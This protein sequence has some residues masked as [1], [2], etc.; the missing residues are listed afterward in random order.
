MSMKNKLVWYLKGK[1]ITYVYIS[2][3]KT[4]LSIIYRQLKKRCDFWAP[5]P[6]IY[7]YFTY[8]T[9]FFWQCGLSPYVKR[10][11]FRI[12]TQRPSNFVNAA[13]P[14]FNQ[15]YLTCHCHISNFE[16]DFFLWERDF[17][18]PC[19]THHPI[20]KNWCNSLTY[21][22]QHNHLIYTTLP[23]YLAILNASP[24]VY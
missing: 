19:P 22:I 4:S 12:P 9:L 1:N 11:K 16:S 21:L 5:R 8:F 24:A 7:V 2:N 13:P 14:N 6:P 17:I 20:A 23:S 15:K 10:K 3:T 18:I